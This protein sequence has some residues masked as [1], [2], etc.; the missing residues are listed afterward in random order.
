MDSSDQIH[1]ALETTPKKE[2]LRGLY[3]AIPIAV[4]YIPVAIAFAVISRS[5]GV[6]DYIIMLLSILVFAGASQFA[7]VGMWASGSAAGEI[8][9][10][11]FVLN[12]RH[13]LFSASLS[14]RLEKDVPRAWSALLAFGV[15]DETFATATF[16][17]DQYLSR[18]Y[19]LG[20]N[21]LA[22]ASWAGG[23]GVGLLLSSV[24]PQIVKNSLGIALYALFIGLVTPAV[25]ASRPGLM[26]LFLALAASALLYWAPV[27]SVVP[28]GWRIII[29]TITAAG[30]GA[31]LISKEVEDQ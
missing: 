11:T 6:P 13:L 20:L 8:I 19:I 21:L 31:L 9:L 3:S 2:L 15:T 16:Q 27:L 30:L 25:R 7:A 4:G 10:A 18:Y 28:S 29:A 1:L 5:L 14:R 26:V 23:T 17:P 12:L 22:W 24:L